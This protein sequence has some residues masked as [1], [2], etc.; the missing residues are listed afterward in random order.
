MKNEN[1]RDL[2]TILPLEKREDMSI[3]KLSSQRTS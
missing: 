1:E 3:R 2:I